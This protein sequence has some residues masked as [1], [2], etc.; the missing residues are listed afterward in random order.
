MDALSSQAQAKLPLAKPFYFVYSVD[1]IRN[2]SHTASIDHE[3]EH[4]LEPRA[5][6]E[7]SY[8]PTMNKSTVICRT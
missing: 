3:Y 1:K 8:T 7:Y 2:I 4:S 6:F 5:C